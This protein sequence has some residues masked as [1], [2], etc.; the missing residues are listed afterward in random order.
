VPRDASFNVDAAAVVAKIRQLGRCIMYA[1]PWHS[2]YE[3]L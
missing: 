1:L 2:L 3:I